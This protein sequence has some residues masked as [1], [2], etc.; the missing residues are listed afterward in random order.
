[1][2]DAAESVGKIV[3][4]NGKAI[5][6]R[7]EPKATKALAFNDD[8]YAMDTI[9]TKN[10]SLKILFED[11]TVMSLAENSKVLITEQ[12]YRPKQGTRNSIFDVLKGK[13]RT[14][15]EKVAGNSDVKLQTPTAVAGIRGTDIG[16]Q[17]DGNKT[18]FLC[19]DGLVETY[20]KGAPEQKVMLEAGQLTTIQSSPPTAPE[21]IPTNVQRS[22]TAQEG[23]ALREVLKQSGGEGLN[24]KELLPPPPPPANN[25]RT[26][27]D[28]Q[29]QGRRN[30][31][32]NHQGSGEA[33]GSRQREDPQVLQSNGQNNGQNHPEGPQGPPPPPPPPPLLP[34][35]NSETPME[36]V[37][38]GG[39][40]PMGG[41]AGSGA[42]VPTTAP[43]DIP[44]TFPTPG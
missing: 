31:G 7:L 6:S 39:T 19:F 16:I 43:V 40:G 25:E 37:P 35:G 18:Q 5:V 30:E 17:V 38:P 24:K 10:G 4:V 41:G 9:E 32:Q 27:N 14:V 3:F 44:V 42:S 2:A 23:P 26:Q 8:I 15:V 28:S 22:Y 29:A 21:A 1:M 11:Q 13:V 20:F 34:G 33:S 36:L 12:I